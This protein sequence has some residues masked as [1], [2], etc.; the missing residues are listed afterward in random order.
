MLSE[1]ILGTMTTNV[2]QLG[3]TVELDN[4]TRRRFLKYLIAGGT[5]SVGIQRAIKETYGKEPEGK[6]IVH[7]YNIRGEPKRVRMISKERHRRIMSLK[8]VLGELRD[9]DGVSGVTIT[10]VTDNEIG[11][12]ILID[13]TSADTTDTVKDKASEIVPNI[14]VTTTIVSVETD[15]DCSSRNDEADT[16]EG[17]LK[18]N[19]D[20]STTDGGTLTFVGYNNNGDELLIGSDHIME[21]NSDMYQP[22]GSDRKIGDFYKRSK[23]Y[24]GEDVTSYTLADD[25]DIDAR[26]TIA[27]PDISGVWDF[28]GLVDE[29]NYNGPV[30]CT[31][32]GAGSCTVDNKAVNAVLGGRR[33][34]HEVRMENRNATGGDSGG[35]WMDSNGDLV[36]IHSGYGDP[37]D[38]D[39]F[40]I[41]SVGSEALVSVNANLYDVTG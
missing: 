22:A 20:Q 26:A 2:P 31:L 11:I 40:D 16:L 1:W 38:G 17:G 35:P 29:L 8:K 37:D 9:H 5:G 7:T 41:G 33:V 28:Y 3:E 10:S 34:Y 6:P 25:I 23:E 21:G 30:D 18:V 12:E 27:V 39:D 24:N 14:P 13:K 36:A 15:G 19:G 32:T 4:Q